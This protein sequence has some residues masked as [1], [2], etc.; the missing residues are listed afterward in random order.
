MTC[1]I[2]QS[3]L[4][5]AA[6]RLRIW[7]DAIGIVLRVG[8]ATGGSSALVVITGVSCLSHTFSVFV[9]VSYYIPSPPPSL[10]P[11]P[12]GRPSV[13]CTPCPVW[14]S[15]SGSPWC[16]E[17]PRRPYCVPSSWK[18]FPSSWSRPPRTSKTRTIWHTHAAKHVN[19]ATH[20]HSH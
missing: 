10:Y 12:A 16:L 20:T 14:L 2:M 19:A 13:T 9:Y 11:T 4:F 15:L 6:Y 7:S 8:S 1:H 18:S 17:P 5:S 3:Q